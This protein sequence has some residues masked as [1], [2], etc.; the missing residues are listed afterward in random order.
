MYAVDK[1]SEEQ[2]IQH[3]LSSRLFR[4]TSL[5]PSMYSVLLLYLY[6][7]NSQTFRAQYFLDSTQNR[8]VGYRMHKLRKLCIYLGMVWTHDF[9]LPKVIP[10]CKVLQYDRRIQSTADQLNGIIKFE[11]RIRGTS[12]VNYLEVMVN[13]EIDHHDR[14]SRELLYIVYNFSIN[15]M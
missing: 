13:L 5:C 14:L 9:L 3:I 8:F 2:V 6:I 4:S 10:V 11:N 7:L 15:I 12:S 1:Q